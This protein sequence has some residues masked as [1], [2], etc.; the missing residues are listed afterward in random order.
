MAIQGDTYQVGYR[1]CRL[2]FA[3]MIIVFSVY[4]VISV[5][6]NIWKCISSFARTTY[7]EYSNFYTY[8]KVAHIQILVVYSFG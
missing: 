6:Q 3:I 8:R 5:Y 1:N 4:R 2:N 7:N